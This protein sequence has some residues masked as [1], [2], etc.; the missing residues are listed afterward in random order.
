MNIK[1]E[2]SKFTITG[3]LEKPYVSKSAIAK[4][5]AKGEDAT[6]LPAL[7]VYTSGGFLKHG[8]YKFSLNVNVA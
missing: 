3:D 5:L 6:K 2:G 4:A 7:S 8:D 1:I